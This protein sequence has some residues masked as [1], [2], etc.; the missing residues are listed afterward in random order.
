M[1]DEH[2]EQTFVRFPETRDLWQQALVFLRVVRSVER[3]TDIQRDA[4]PLRLDLD[5][6]TADFLRTPMNTD[7]HKV[8]FSPFPCLVTG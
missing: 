7:L 6:G 5:T 2:S 4:L 3:Q 1:G 8:P